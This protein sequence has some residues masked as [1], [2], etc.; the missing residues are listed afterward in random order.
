MV[1]TQLHLRGMYSSP[2]LLSKK[3]PNNL[4]G[5]K[6]WSEKEFR[7]LQEKDMFKMKTILHHLHNPGNTQPLPS[8]WLPLIFLYYLLYLYVSYP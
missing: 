4:A 8:S 5:K 1:L 2:C 3:S 7:F 6:K